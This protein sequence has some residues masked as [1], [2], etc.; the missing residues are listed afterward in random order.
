LDVLRLI[1]AK[2][3]GEAYLVATLVAVEYVRLAAVEGSMQQLRVGV[4]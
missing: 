1:D 4:Q 3:R 2:E